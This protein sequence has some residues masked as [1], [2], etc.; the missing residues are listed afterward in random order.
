MQKITRFKELDI[1]KGI[2]ILLIIVYHLVYR[3]QDSA[4]DKLI[5]SSGWAF[6]A[7]F[8][9]ISGFT[10]G[11]DKRSVK[12]NYVN[13]VKKLI[14][15]CLASECVALIVGG[16]YCMLR[17]GFTITDV[18]HDVLVTFI[19]PELGVQISREWGEGG[20]LFINA[21]PVWYIWAMIFT[22]LLFYPI[23][24]WCAGNRGRW[25][26]SVVLLLGIQIPLYIFVNPL[27][28]Q[29]NIVPTFTVFMLLGRLFKETGFFLGLSGL[30]IWQHLLI[31]LVGFAA[32]FGL[33]C[34]G[35]T[36]WYYICVYGTRG[37]WDIPLVIVQILIFAPALFSLAKL[38]GKLSRLNLALSWLGSHTL[39][40]LIWH[41]IFGMIFEDLFGTYLKMGQ[42]WYLENH[43]IMVTGEIIGMSLLVGLLSLIAS[44]LLALGE[45]KV[46]GMFAKK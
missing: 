23:A 39:T 45:D 4:A 34:F 33:F 29:L 20:T 17:L 1:M 37:G 3:P 27:P 15:P 12:E 2:G 11:V 5:R 30:R 26:I 7:L 13:R 18:F 16:I 22:E 35:G 28:W 32:H 21:S 46:R 14:L 19:R 44:V 8:F 38:L 40:I 42:N 10:A 6:I 31:V 24:K 25:I 43:G 36:E 9:L 41:S